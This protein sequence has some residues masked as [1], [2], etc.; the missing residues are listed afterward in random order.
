MKIKL[1]EKRKGILLIAAAAVVS[2]IGVYFRA[3]SHYFVSGTVGT[4]FIFGLMRLRK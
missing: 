2:I 3:F 1:T 4:L